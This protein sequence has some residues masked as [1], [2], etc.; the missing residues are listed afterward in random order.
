MTRELQLTARGT[1][2][3]ENTLVRGV[4]K[5]CGVK[6]RGIVGEWPIENMGRQNLGGCL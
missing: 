5:P 2:G 1:Q 6:R 3:G 4:P